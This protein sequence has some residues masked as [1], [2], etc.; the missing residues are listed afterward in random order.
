MILIICYAIEAFI[1]YQ[2]YLNSLGWYRRVQIVK[3]QMGRYCK[4]DFIFNCHCNRYQP[5]NANNTVKSADK[6]RVK[7]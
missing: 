3:Y 5:L 1:Y 7:F 2:L 4:S 6:T